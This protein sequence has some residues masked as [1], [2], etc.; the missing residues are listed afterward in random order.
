MP[1]SSRRAAQWAWGLSAWANHAFA[2]TVVV[3]LFPIFF[4]KYWAASLP[5]TSS[6]FYL[7]LSNSSA[8]FTVMLLAPWLGALADRRGRKK[9]WFGLFT[10]LGTLATALLALIGP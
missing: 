4:D 7:G 3:G 9:F 5:G 10:L 6:T 2:T 8:S 1:M